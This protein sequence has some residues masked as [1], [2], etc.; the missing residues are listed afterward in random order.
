MKATKGFF[1]FLF[2]LYIGNLL[3]IALPIPI[4]GSVYGMVILLLVL[5]FRW[6]SM[7]QIEDIT[8]ILLTHMPILFLPGAANII[9]IYP[10]IKGEILK[11]VIITT[12]S[13]VL[14]MV[15]TGWTVQKMI[16]WQEARKQ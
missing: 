7:E 2:L 9:I 5:S 14:V 1:I 8:E 3:S 6:I 16:Q 12:V 13:T 10:D 15:S 11:L 4:P